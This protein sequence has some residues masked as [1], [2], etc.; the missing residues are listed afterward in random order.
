MHA[1]TPLKCVHML[2]A[3][4][5]SMPEISF[6]VLRENTHPVGM[7]AIKTLDMDHAEIKSMHILA[8]LRGRGLARRLLNHVI[9]YAHDQN[10]TRLSLE[11]GSQPSFAPAR[12]LYESAG[13]SYCSAFNDYAQSDSSTF[14]TKILTDRP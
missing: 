10:L 13:F 6:F 3:H 2:D 1:D 5:L 8:E 7:A 9:K 4:E 11:T 12:A 14:M